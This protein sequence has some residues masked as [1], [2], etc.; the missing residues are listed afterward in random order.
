MAKAIETLVEDIYHVLSQDNDHDVSEENLEWAAD[1]FKDVLR[2]RFKERVK[3]ASALRFSSLGKK[4]RQLW[5]E[6]HPPENVEVLSPQTIFKFL[7]GDMIEILLLFLAK[8]SGHEVTHEQHEVEVDG[9]KG[10]TDAVIDGIPIDCKSASP[11]SFNKFRDGSFIFD[12]PFGYIPQLSGYCHALGNTSRAGFLVADKVSGSIHFAELSGADI[13]A[14]PPATRI[15]HLKGVLSESSPPPRCYKAEPEGKSGNMKLGIGCSY[16]KFKDACWADANG[17]K[18][19]RRFWYSRGPTWLTEV[20]K[21]P[22]VEE[23]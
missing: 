14:N 6:E 7:Y 18:G 17:G 8:E 15:T 12:D 16:C 5:Y 23:A 21:E 4:D 2:T 11:Y 3:P 19:L 22:K 1:V 20:H 9:V 10:H 13:S